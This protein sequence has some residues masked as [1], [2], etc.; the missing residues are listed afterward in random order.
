VV[1][2][3]LRGTLQAR[4]TEGEILIDVGGVGYRVAMTAPASAGLGPLGTEAFVHV[5]THVREDAIV[6]YGFGH[7]DERRCFEALLG[8]HGVGPTLALA[9]LAVLSPAALATAVVEDDIDT[10]CLVPGVGRKTAARLALELGTRLDLPEL[11]VTEAEMGGVA[12]ARPAAEGGVMADRGVRS[13]VRAALVELGY[14]PDEIAHAL[15]SLGDAGSVE[16]ALR[17]ALRELA[18]TTPKAHR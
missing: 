7:A 11:G 15:T 16:E 4:L 8:A 2:G 10:L 14:A 12:G 5:H 3:S 9:I 1:I 6:L 18:G 17:L 13:D